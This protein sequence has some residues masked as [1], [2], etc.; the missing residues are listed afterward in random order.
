[1]NIELIKG[2]CF[3][4]LLLVCCAL[5]SSSQLKKNT[6]QVSFQGY[7]NN[8][9]PL[10]ENPYIELPLGAVK[11]LGWL[12]EMLLRQKSGATGNLDVLYPLVMN[13]RNGWLGGDGDQWER[14]PYWI[15]GL[16]P[17]AYILND[18]QLVEKAK[19][20]VEWA[21][22]SRQP[23][24]YFGPSK[25]Y[26]PER[27]LQRD[28]SRDWWPKIVMLK[29]LKQYYSAT[30]DQRV[31]DL[32]TAYFKHQLKELP[33]KPLDHWT[34]WARYRGGDNLMVVYWLY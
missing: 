3:F 2:R 26:T 34:F 14:G 30:R 6:K 4:I 1:M 17:L 16:L 8:R 24:G 25:D 22:A 19:P 31:I 13:Q 5:L 27:G 11:P 7:T 21:L 18:K 33:S 9:A 28:N 15:D 20:W 23:D 32:M 10:R 12:K 29:V